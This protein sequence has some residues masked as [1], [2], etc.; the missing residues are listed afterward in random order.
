MIWRI[1]YK[2]RITNE[3]WYIQT[4]WPSVSMTRIDEYLKETWKKFLYITKIDGS[5]EKTSYDWT[6]YKD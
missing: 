2:D 5:E 6:E 1:Y 4:K 3:S